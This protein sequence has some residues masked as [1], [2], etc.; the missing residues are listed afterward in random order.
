[1]NREQIAA[2][3][4]S[5]GLGFVSKRLIEVVEKVIREAEAAARAE[6][7]SFARAVIAA[8]RAKRGAE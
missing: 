2:R 5:S 6:E 8:D 3:L 7:L 4:R 1:M